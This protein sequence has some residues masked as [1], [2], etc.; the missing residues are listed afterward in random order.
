MKRVG[1]NV[2]VHRSA[3]EELP[4]ALQE[5]VEHA[6]LGDP[7]PDWD[8]VR[9]SQ[10]ASEVM[11]GRTTDWSRD[12]HPRLL[13]S[14]TLKYRGRNRWERQWFVTAARE[15]EDPPLY[16]RKELMLP[17]G[18]HSRHVYERLTEQEEAAG[19]LGRSDIGRVSQW[20]RALREAGYWLRGHTLVRI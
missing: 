11:F 13:E 9:V 20:E 14:V 2:Y 10:D 17:K 5:A 1:R 7:L 12:P 15:Y 16:H 8:V 3:V 18:H 4:E 6:G 19:L